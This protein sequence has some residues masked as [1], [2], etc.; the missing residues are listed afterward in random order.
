MRW[1][2]EMEKAD[3]YGLGE[4]ALEVWTWSHPAAAWSALADLLEVQYQAEL[5]RGDAG[6]SGW[7]RDQVWRR[8][9]SALSH[10]NRGDEIETHLRATADAGDTFPL[11]EFLHATDRTAEALKSYVSAVDGL[12]HQHLH[13][14]RL[15]EVLEGLGRDADRASIEAELFFTAPSEAAFTAAVTSAQQ[16]GCRD[17]VHS[18][19]LAFLRTGTRPGANWAL[20]VPLARPA[21]RRYPQSWPDARTL[22]EIALAEGCVDDVLKWSRAKGGRRDATVA[23]ALADS[24]PNEAL[25]ILEPAVSGL[26][27]R[28]VIRNYAAAVPLIRQ[29]RD[30]LQAHD[31]NDEWRAYAEKL[32][33]SN[34][35]RPRFIERLQPLIQDPTVRNG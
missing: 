11:A 25:R 5:A 22:T 15:R 29:I 31:R 20:P 35:R 18:A 1:V 34:A 16:A 26:L 21:P 19:A 9:N 27:D 24:Y 30:T 10:S 12:S 17:A 8:L 7:R 13:W 3:G 23:A 4:A 6:G 28:A 14:K 32:R 2:W 33:V